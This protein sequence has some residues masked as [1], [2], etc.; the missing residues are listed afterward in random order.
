M[1]TQFVI[2]TL[3]I[4]TWRSTFV[5]LEEFFLPG[6]GPLVSN[7]CSLLLGIVLTIVLFAGE[8]LIAKV[9][10]RIDTASGYD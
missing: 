10:K 2:T 6:S 8:G 4:L 3:T 9:G 5:I 7:V 1:L